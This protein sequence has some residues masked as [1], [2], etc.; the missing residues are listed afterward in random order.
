M[1]LSN[2]LL[3]HDFHHFQSHSKPSADIKTDAIFNI[4][5]L[6]HRWPLLLN[7]W[8]SLHPG[9]LL[10]YSNL[11]LLINTWNILPVMLSSC[12]LVCSLACLVNSSSFIWPIIFSSKSKSAACG[13]GG[14]GL[15]GSGLGGAIG[16]FSCISSRSIVPG[17]NP[18][19]F[20][21][22]SQVLLANLTLTFLD[23]YI[24]LALL[25]DKSYNKQAPRTGNACTPYFA[26]AQ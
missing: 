13:E 7:S 10:L 4:K 8:L 12:A 25:A 26:H 22:S 6:D 16:D 1:L 2:Y 15:G 20:S 11:I 17:E 3:L 18:I 9:L 5:D 21:W 24:F 19:P 23:P 14:A